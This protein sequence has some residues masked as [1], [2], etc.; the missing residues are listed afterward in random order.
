[1]KKLLFALLAESEE[2]SNDSNELYSISQKDPDWDRDRDRD[3]DPLMDRWKK[4][5][6]VCVNKVKVLKGFSEVLRK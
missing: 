6:R 4:G 3:R 1:M 5:P 2:E